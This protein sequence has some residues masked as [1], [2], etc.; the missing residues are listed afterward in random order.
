M[1]CVNN[2]QHFAVIFYNCHTFNG[3][4]YLTFMGISGSLV[5]KQ[6]SVL[7]KDR[8]AR[9]HFLIKQNFCHKEVIEQSTMKLCFS[10]QALK[11]CFLG[12]GGWEAWS[13]GEERTKQNKTKPNQHFRTISVFILED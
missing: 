1:V 12:G 9:R 10:L 6:F 2:L 13:R 8:S 7:I 11:H 4:S 5:R 3:L